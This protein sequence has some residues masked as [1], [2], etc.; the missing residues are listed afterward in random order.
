MPDD[1]VHV[2]PASA[3]TPTASSLRS[4][5]ATAPGVALRTVSTATDG[6][7]RRR[8]SANSSIENSS[9]SMSRSGTRP[10]LALAGI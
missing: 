9:L 5:P 6:T 10:I 1:D 4:N 8:L 3:R 7:W 2:T